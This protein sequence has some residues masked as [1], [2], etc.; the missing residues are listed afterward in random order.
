VDGED[1]AGMLGPCLYWEL[2]QRYVEEL[3]AAVTRCSK[4]LILVGFRPGDVVEGVLRVE[5]CRVS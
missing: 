1:F 4:D 2:V 3:D 5:P